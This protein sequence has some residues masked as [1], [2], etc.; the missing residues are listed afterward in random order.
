MLIENRVR[1]GSYCG[2]AKQNVKE[3]SNNSAEEKMA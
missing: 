1:Y 2:K 3:A